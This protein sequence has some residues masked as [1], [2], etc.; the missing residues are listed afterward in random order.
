MAAVSRG[1]LR[2]IAR[3]EALADR[4]FQSQQLYHADR[5]KSLRDGSFLIIA[6]VCLIALYGTPRIDEPLTEAW[7]RALKTLLQECPGFAENGRAN[8]FSV[9]PA[10]V[11]IAD[12]FRK[13]VLPRLPG[14]DDNKKIYRVLAEAPQWLLYHTNVDRC[15]AACGIKVPDV[16]SMQRFDRGLWFPGILHQGPFDQQRVLRTD[17]G[18]PAKGPERRAPPHPKTT[19]Q[20]L[21]EFRVQV[22]RNFLIADFREK[23]AEAFKNGSFRER[24]LGI[25]PFPG[26]VCTGRRPPPHLR[27]D[28]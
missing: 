9:D 3:L 13:C 25:P 14:A 27:D 18:K 11:V 24:P 28:D 10:P 17:V 23:A 20:V 19:H 22:I 21:R 12:D 5:Q 6:S 1:K 4:R 8:P 2:R 16:S 7:I 26:W 15:C